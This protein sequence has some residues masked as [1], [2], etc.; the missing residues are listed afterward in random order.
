MNK[1][2]LSI[3]ES[4]PV[5]FS[6]FLDSFDLCLSFPNLTGDHSLDCR[7]ELCLHVW[8]P[9]TASPGLTLWQYWE[10][11]EINGHTPSRAHTWWAG[12]QWCQECRRTRASLNDM[13]GWATR[14]QSLESL[15]RTFAG[16]EGWPGTSVAWQ[17]SLGQVWSQE[18]TE[19]D[20]VPRQSF[21]HM[22]CHVLWSV[23]AGLLEGM[24]VCT[25]TAGLVFN[26]LQ[27]VCWWLNMGVH[28]LPCQERSLGR[29]P[30]LAQ[31]YPWHSI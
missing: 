20:L 23:T 1:L 7:S 5:P 27:Y 29:W 21:R 14:T 4:T 8:M 28:N 10:V 12:S 9:Y 16:L 18:S 30:S 6:V 11:A 19:K 3:P 25:A 15:V 17:C 24:P 26:M 13:R 22:A 2:P 31:H